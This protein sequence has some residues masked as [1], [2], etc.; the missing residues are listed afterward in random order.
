MLTKKQDLINTCINYSNICQ[1]HV[2]YGVIDEY[3]YTYVLESS[4]VREF[5]KD[6]CRVYCKAKNGNLIL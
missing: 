1:D 5:T 4:I 6:G 2:F 3:G